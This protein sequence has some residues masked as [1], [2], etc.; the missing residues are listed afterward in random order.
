MLLPRVR[1]S[2]W[3]QTQAAGAGPVANGLATTVRWVG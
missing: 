3:I 1:I 2:V